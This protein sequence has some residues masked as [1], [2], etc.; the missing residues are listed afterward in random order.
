MSQASLVR[1]IVRRVRREFENRWR[2]RIWES[3]YAQFADN[4]HN[5][6]PLKISREIYLELAEEVRS[7]QATQYRKFHDELAEAFKFSP[8]PEFVRFIDDLALV[9]QVGSK[10]HVRLLYLHGYLLEA[11]QCACLLPT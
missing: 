11:A 10:K 3:W 5:V 7:R 8:T 2:T 9:T 1:R 4:P 6:D